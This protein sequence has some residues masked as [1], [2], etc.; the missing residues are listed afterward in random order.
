MTF[1]FEKYP[2]NKDNNDADNSDDNN[3]IVTMVTEERLLDPSE[4]LT[5]TCNN[6][7]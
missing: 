2:H 3:D 4:L 7:T 6:M 1:G 5:T